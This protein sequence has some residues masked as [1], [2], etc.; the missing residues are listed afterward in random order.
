[1][2]RLV[3]L[4]LLALA[5]PALAQHAQPYAGLQ[6]R[7][8]KALSE[9]EVAD[10]RAGR[11]MG[12][13][14]AAELNG[15]PGPLHVLEHADALGLT[16]EQRGRSQALFDAMKADAVP[17]GQT[18]DRAG[19]RPRPR[20]RRPQHD[21]RHAPAPDLGDRRDAS[22][23]AR[24]APEIPP[25]A[26]RDPHARPARALRRAARLCRRASEGTIRTAGITAT[27][28]RPAL[29]H[30]IVAVPRVSTGIAHATR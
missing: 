28:W 20:L 14:L 8:V 18:A 2:Q 30:L 15:Y 13:A 22:G 25:G 9:R 12:L 6:E 24:G 27:W 23:V 5:T 16:P 10:L 7:P 1:M 4:I 19:D 11:G 17:L 26:D 29:R 21:A 3:L